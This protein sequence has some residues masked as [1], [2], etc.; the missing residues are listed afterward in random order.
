M[1]ESSLF[2]EPLDVLFPRGNKLF[3]EPGSFGE[4]LIPPWPSALAGALRSRLLVQSGIDPAAFAAGQAEHEAVGRVDAP[5]PFAVTAFT[6]ARRTG[7]SVEVLMPPPADLYIGVGKD[8]APVGTLLRP[9]P[10]PPSVSCSATLPLLPVLAE[11]ER[12]K[13]RG[14]FW[15]DERGWA[16]Y[17]NGAPPRADSLVETSA[18]WATELRVGVGL[19]PAKRRAEDGRLFTIQA[20]AMRPNI[21]FLV[22]VAGA[23][24]VGGG[25]VRF[26][27]DGRAA[28]LHAVGKRLPEPDYEA[29]ARDRRCRLV[30]T[31]PGL[32]AAG[33]LPTGADP[34]QRRGDGAVRFTLHGVAGWIV[35]AAVARS[36][37]VSGWDLAARRPKPALSA[38]PVGSVWW[39]ELDEG[40]ATSAL[41]K[42]V[43]NGLW[44]D[45]C[46]D[47]A[48]RAEGF[49]R[50]TIAVY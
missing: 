50:L 36:E 31:T 26:G 46:E 12:S 16:A 33:W 19:D 30:L 40:I 41:R 45:P 5:G 2:I 28:A 38:A 37:V 6:V 29:I 1:N 49:N 7:G 14:G 10:C 48:R 15:L 34:Q 39:L 42:L 20:L 27:G 9:R 18:L 23:T 11:A 32:F 4:A 13:P 44:S 43:E 35:S 25:F 24:M 17:L 22:A 21:G 8:G 3:G 47:A